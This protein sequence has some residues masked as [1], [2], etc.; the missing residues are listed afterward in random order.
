MGRRHFNQTALWL[1]LFVV[2]AQRTAGS[3]Q[4]AT[5]TGVTADAAQW[6]S[7]IAQFEAA[8][9]IS[10]PAKG[11]VLFVGSS[12]IR[13][14]PDLKASFPGVNVL[15]RG[16]GG[17]QLSDVNF[18]APRIVLPYEPRLIVL[19][20]GDNVVAEGHSPEEVFSRYRTFV[21]LV[22][23]SLPQ[24]RIAFVSIKPSGSRWH[25]ADKMRKA[26]ELVREYTATDPK[27]LYVDVF[28]PMLG[29]SGVPRPD[30]FQADSLHMN[31]NGYAIWRARLDPI[32]RGNR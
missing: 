9:R 7:E 18:F 22:R 16:F 15:Q 21:S 28:T 2:V 29:P 13:M 20:A 30:L 19:Y 26:N 8:D 23:R 10:P 24:T 31:S 1:G 3:Q 17:S 32:V 4:Q 12:S 14:W 25:L 27:L 5:S 11:G 6:E